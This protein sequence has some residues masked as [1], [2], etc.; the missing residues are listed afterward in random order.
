MRA[1]AA[2]PLFLFGGLLI[3]SDSEAEEGR[4]RAANQL[5]VYY[6]TNLEESVL[7]DRL[8][9]DLS[10][11]RF[12]GGIVFLSHSPSNPQL[13]DPNDFGVRQEGIRKRWATA[14]IEP[15]TVRLGDSYASFGNG[16]VLRVVEDQAV[17]FDNVLDGMAIEAEL[18][19]FEIEG[20]AGTNSLGPER[21][22]V[23]GVSAL[24][25]ADA[26]W[27]VSFNGAIVDS[28][29]GTTVVPGRDQ[30]GGIE[31]GAYLP[32]GFEV[33]AEY[34]VRHYKP[35]REGRSPA[36]DGHATYLQ[37][38]G[39]VGPVSL[40]LEAKDLLRF[41]HGYTIPPTVARQHTST[42]L[43]RGSHVP[44]IRLEDERGFQAEALWSPL[45]DVYLTG[46][47]SESEARHS[48]LPAWEA[49][50]MI[51]ADFAGAHWV[52]L[53]AETEEK[54]REGIDRTFFERITF[55]GD[56]VR[57]LGRG[58]SLEVLYETQA[59]QQQDLATSHFEYP[60]KYRDHIAAATLSLSPKHTWSVNY[61]WTDSPLEE[62]DSWLWVEWSIR[63]GVVGQ[64]TLAGGALRGGQVCSGGVCKLVDPFEGGRLELLTNF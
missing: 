23:K 1:A 28:V 49:F 21:T 64:L 14:T 34:A 12:S 55:G 32:G 16:L 15:I 4:I 50:G 29:D 38:S 7:D 51:E 59:I 37:A 43:N 3:A 9:L 47:Y 44:N 58:W 39:F 61:E 60:L 35:E 17:D 27:H 5:E 10:W 56:V 25:F 52:L 26:G 20:I 40:F 54:V 53:G 18:G 2:V 13:L 36:P 6:D 48:N 30:I 57:E 33:A 8:D 62:K 45:Q 46:N 11:G 19:R 42:L 31:G 24:F 63:F 22:V 41:D